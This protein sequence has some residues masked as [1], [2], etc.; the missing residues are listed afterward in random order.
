MMVRL[1]KVFIL[2]VVCVLVSG[3]LFS[4]Q[5]A[6]EQVVNASITSF[7]EYMPGGKTADS[8]LIEMAA[9]GHE[10]QPDEIFGAEFGTAG[11]I[12]E[13]ERGPE[14]PQLVTSFEEYARIYGSHPEGPLCHT[15]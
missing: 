9:A 10:Y 4:S 6:D 8:V 13:T 15:R 14:T 2:T 7:S 11:F 1:G 12:G 3:I 5:V